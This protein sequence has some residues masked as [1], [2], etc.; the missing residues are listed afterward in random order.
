VSRLRSR[1]REKVRRLRKSI[2]NARAAF[3]PNEQGYELRYGD[4]GSYRMVYR[5][6]TAD[7]KVFE[8]GLDNDIFFA[9]IPE[10]I[11]AAGDV[12]IDVG[13]HIGTF[14]LPAARRVPQGRVYAVEASRETSEYLRANVALNGLDNVDVLNVG[15]GGM[16]GR[17]LLSHD[18]GNWGHSI[19]M[20]LSGKAEEIEVMTLDTLMR[21]RGIAR[22]QLLRLNC[23]GAEFPALLAASPETL[24]RIQR[25]LVLY[26]CD[27]ARAF[28]VG[29][30]VA[31]LEESGFHTEIRNRATFRGWLVAVR[32]ADV[33]SC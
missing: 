23:E 31:H 5:G 25:M 9:G 15:L 30:L 12:I 17:A 16:N 28:D 6:G 11:P 32:D 20:R 29:D 27:L 13:A 4:V 14:T 19:T 7:E 2:T 22:C 26:H 1:L 21:S 3:H 24:R 8:H 10:Y 18:E 33:S